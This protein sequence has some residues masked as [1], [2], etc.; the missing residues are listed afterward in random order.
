[1]RPRKVVLCVGSNERRLGIQMFVVETW[2]YRVLTAHTASEALG[3]LQREHPGSI[4]L[5]VL[6]V[7]LPA[8]EPLLH[9]AAEF[10]PGIHTIALSLSPAGNC[11]VDVFLTC[12]FGSPSE[13]HEQIKI[14]LHKK[15]GP[16]KKPVEGVRPQHS[17]V[18]YG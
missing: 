11:K 3:I 5:M 15:R 10:Q 9:Y 12:H 17:E 6:E 2:G 18:H 14:L 8:T 1:M 4:D 7:P 13:L 16:K